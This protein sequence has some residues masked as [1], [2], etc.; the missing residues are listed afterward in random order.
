MPSKNLLV[1]QITN[2]KILVCVGVGI[3]TAIGILT[4][5]AIVNYVVENL[6]P[7]ELKI[8]AGKKDGEGYIISEAIAK[9]VRDKTNIKIDVCETDGTDDNLK[10]LGGSKLEGKINCKND[11]SPNLQTVELATAQAGRVQSNMPVRSIATLYEDHFQLLINIKK[12]KIDDKN[13]DPETFDFSSLKIIGTP[14][15]GGRR[16]SLKI[17]AENLQHLEFNNLDITEKEEIDQISNKFDAVFYVRTLGNKKINSLIKAGWR[18]VPIKNVL[19]LQ[20]M[21]YYYYRVSMIPEKNYQ[22]SV[23]SK[24]L[25]TIALDR[26]L[27]TKKD[28]P[29][30]VIKK[31]VTVLE[32]NHQDIEFEISHN[33][34]NKAV[35][36]LVRNIKKPSENSDVQ[37][38]PGVDTYYRSKEEPFLLKN[39]DFMGFVLT[40]CGLLY[41]GYSNLKNLQT[42]Q[43]I[44]NLIDLSK[45]FED[46]VVLQVD[47]DLKVKY[48]E[49]KLK[50][51]FQQHKQVDGLFKQASVSLDSEGFRAF[52]E[53]YKSTREIIERG[54]E[55]KQRKFSSF[56]VQEIINLQN[57]QDDPNELLKKLEQKFT[58]ITGKLLEDEIFSRESFLIIT[59]TYDIVRDTIELRKQEQSQSV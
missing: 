25:Q 19:A 24:E 10:A 6:L 44:N 53:V 12:L 31:I 29:N 58:E 13:F 47:K 43:K 9:V 48:L 38:H 51:L 30:W 21:G 3:I 15:G 50:K 49:E 8:G 11:K 39:A 18:L 56:Y 2:K 40:I 16:Q 37:R 32:E 42:N 45:N 7:Y 22:N 26:L 35:A 41:A 4:T 17:I 33:N 27:L 28:I 5:W 23:P 46:D 57:S 54:I 59:E 52:S 34:G 36:S 55:D 14:K 1:L 20:N